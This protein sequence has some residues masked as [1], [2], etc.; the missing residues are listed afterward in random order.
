M[1]LAIKIGVFYGA[2][3]AAVVLAALYLAVL[4]LRV[5]R[6]TLAR[7]AAAAR[8]A[9]SLILPLAAVAAI[10]A[11][12]ELASYSAAGGARD[13]APPLALLRGLLPLAGYAALPVVLLAAA[14]WTMLARMPRQGRKDGT[15][16]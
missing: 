8:G 10:W 5:R 13:G 4:W 11:T 3:V 7:G 12:A 9:W 14:F 2:P 16:R 1:W 15:A 6:G